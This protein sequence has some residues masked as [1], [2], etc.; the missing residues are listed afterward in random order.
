[1]TALLEPLPAHRERV[2]RGA[3]VLDP[4]TGER[5]EPVDVRVRGDRVVEVGA[6]RGGDGEDLAGLTLLPGLV[7]AHVHAL[8]P[9]VASG[10]PG[11]WL[12]EQV[13]RNLAGFLAA[14][15]VGVRD[16]LSPPGAMR[17]VAGALASGLL[18]G[19]RVWSSGPMLTREGGY[20][21]FL[22]PLPGPFRA[23]AGPMR[24]DL[25][26]PDHARQV[27]RRLHR[28]GFACVKVGHASLREDFVTPSTHLQPD[29]LDAVCHEAHARGLHVAVHHHVADDLLG[30]LRSPVDSLEHVPYDRPLTGE[31][32]EAVARAGVAVVPTLT[33]TDNAALFD[34]KDL[35]DPRVGGLFVPAVRGWLRGLQPRWRSA[36]P[37]LSAFG[38]AR[39]NLLHSRVVHGTAAD[40]H[41]AGVSL[42]T[43][44]DMGAGLSFPGEVVSEVEALHR[45]GQTP[46]EALGAATVAPRRLLGEELPEVTPGGLADLIAV[47][48]DPA[49][50]PGALRRVR[51]VGCRGRWYRPVHE[52]RTWFP[53]VSS[54][55]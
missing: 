16:L 1:M 4:R 48:G 14:G 26:S 44:T 28:Q 19:P 49:E 54:S 53:W 11:L 33:Y 5:T 36:D 13:G 21:A 39:A 3:R 22:E 52:N 8:S 10:P 47:E 43:G 51:L 41:A 27:V 32:I 31:E 2:L 15:V 23:L 40:L 9:Y 38:F 12:G 24:V 37:D 25:L 46:L 20:P 30:L 35:H 34:T 42:L 45:A 18:V 55:G 50:D 7:N 29:V 17:L 6:L